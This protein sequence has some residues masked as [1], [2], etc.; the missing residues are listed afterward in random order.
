MELFFNVTFKIAIG[1]SRMAAAI[2]F[3]AVD[4]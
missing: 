1:D 3:P 2:S 4:R